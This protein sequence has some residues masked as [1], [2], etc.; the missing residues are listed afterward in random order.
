MINNF[1]KIEA[2]M[3]EILE[4]D[5][6]CQFLK[7][8]VVEL[9]EKYIKARI[10]FEEPVINSYGSTHGG[11]LYSIADIIAGTVAC[12]SGKFCCTVEGNMNYLLPAISKDYIYVEAKRVRDGAHLVVVK[13]KLK[14]DRGKL[15]DDGSFTFFKTDNDV[16]E[17]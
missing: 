6:F 12:L 4:N 16:A 7:L 5:K 14:D 8:E 11:V 10:P 15:L 1:D 2:A 13:V 3:R 9:E 17:G